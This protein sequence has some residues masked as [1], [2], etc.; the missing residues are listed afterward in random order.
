MS[1]FSTSFERSGGELFTFGIG[2]L[3]ALMGIS[4]IIFNEPVLGILGVVV[5][6]I[7]VA[8]CLGKST[9]D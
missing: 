4:G 9:A 5:L 3:G 8:S 1:R 7:T 2:A 6:L